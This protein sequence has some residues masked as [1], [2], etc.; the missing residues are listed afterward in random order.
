MTA[1]DRHRT[2][3]GDARMKTKTKKDTTY[4]VVAW[5]DKELRIRRH[6]DFRSA[7]AGCYLLRELLH[8]KGSEDARWQIIEGL[9]E[10]DVDEF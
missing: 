8:G 5:N 3:K 10:I 1:L 4:T 6:S 7:E 2:N 9:L